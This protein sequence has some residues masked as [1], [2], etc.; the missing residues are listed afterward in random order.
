MK[1]K[2]LIIFLLSIFLSFYTYAQEPE[3]DATDDDGQD[4]EIADVHHISEGIGGNFNFTN[5]GDQYLIGARFKPDLSFGKLGFGLDVPIMVDL[6]TGKVRVDEFQDGIGAL[7]IIKYVRW[8]VKKRDDVYF[9]IGELRDGQLG[10]GALISDYNN[11]ISFEKR[12]LGFEFDFVFKK[13]FGI[14][15]LYSD[16]N[17]NSFTML[18]IRPYY[19]PF[20]ATEIP[21]IRTFELGL[22]YVTDHDQ[23]VLTQNDIDFYRKNYFLDKGINSFSADLGLYLLNFKWL[24]WS[25]Y[26]QGGYTPKIKSDTLQSYIA[27]F[28]NDEHLQNYSA[29][30]GW[31][32]GSDFK[33]NFLGN[34]L[35]INYRAERFWNSDYY[36]SRFYNFTYE[37]NKDNRIL[38]QVYS[39]KT[40][41]MYMKLGISILDKIILHTNIIFEDEFNSAHPAELYFGLDLSNLF[42]KVT[43]YTSMNQGHITN[44]SDIYKFSDETMFETL[45]AWTFYTVPVINLQ[46]TAGVDFK[47]TYA[48]LSD[49]NFEATHYVSPFFSINLPLNKEEKQPEENEL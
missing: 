40:D 39:Q 22:G 35:K 14:E 47:W 21:I 29:G 10:F 7:R 37:L 36:V 38:Q 15:L 26:G 4:F 44:L 9:R 23:T 8:G 33:F 27:A 20:G 48:F 30:M 43:F 49:Q 46:F 41:G 2:K 19:K 34:L 12:K 17:F 28:P 31:A 6:T 3:G 1:T 42:K 45:L 24:R 5:I 18:G 32:F 16:I 25:V 11:S 13:K